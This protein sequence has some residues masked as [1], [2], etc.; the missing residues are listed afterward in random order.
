MNSDM[1]VE[2]STIAAFVFTMGTMVKLTAADF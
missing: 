2:G 1:I